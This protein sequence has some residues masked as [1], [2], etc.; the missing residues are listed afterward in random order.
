M[1]WVQ[2]PVDNSASMVSEET[3]VEAAAEAAEDVIFETYDRSSVRDIDI[4]VRF[5]D[6]ELS[7]DVLVNTN[8]ETR[9]AVEREARVVED[10]IQAAT[11]AVDDLLD[12][13]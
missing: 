6:R 1:D 13:A 7:V 10:A 4:T 12:A 11:V 2:A 5:E 8:A 9:E 3:V